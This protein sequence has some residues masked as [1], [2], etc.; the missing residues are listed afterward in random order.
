MSHG[1]KD[2]AVSGAKA[3]AIGADLDHHPLFRSG[4]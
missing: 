4:P 2:L 3:M 1:Q